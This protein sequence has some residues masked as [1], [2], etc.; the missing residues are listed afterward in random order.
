MSSTMLIA[1]SLDEALSAIANGAKPVAGGT[2]LVVAARSGKAMLPERL[3]AIHRLDELVG[4]TQATGGVRLGAL[5]SHAEVAANQ[6]V[7]ERYTAL[8][9]A[10]TIVGSEATRLHGTIGGNLMNASPAMEIGGPL[11]CFDSIV[12]LRSMTG[13]RTISL[14]ELL[15]GPG[16]TSASPDELLTVVELREPPPSSGSCYVRLEYRREMEIA[17]AGATCRVSLEN[18]RIIEARVALTAVAPTVLRVP[19]AEAILVG[20]DGGRAAAAAAARKA[21]AAARPI[22]DVRATARYR[23]ATCAVLVR[24]VIEAAVSRARGKHVAI[25]ASDALFGAD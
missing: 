22:S 23:Q 11:L 21:A 3:V 5:T 13:S 12:T 24:R 14:S 20:T 10:S 15:A 25:P 19:A 16:Q 6:L 18:E 7:R 2:D 17:V 4:I 1:P 8:A 9:D